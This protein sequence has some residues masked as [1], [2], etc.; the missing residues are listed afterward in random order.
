MVPSP[1]FMRFSRAH[2]PRLDAA[3][4]VSGRCPPFWLRRRRS[5]QRLLIDPR[6]IKTTYGSYRSSNVPTPRMMSSVPRGAATFGRDLK[7]RSHDPALREACTTAV[8]RAWYT[9]S[10]QV[11]WNWRAMASA[12]VAEAGGSWSRDSGFVRNGLLADQ[13]TPTRTLRVGAGPHS[14]ERSELPAL[15]SS[16]AST[17]AKGERG[18]ECAQCCSWTWDDLDHVGVLGVA[19]A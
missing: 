3:R 18:A 14:T 10:T 15:P 7:G 4:F 6:L 13:A 8:Y 2:T 11:R 16:P 1:Q 17:V 12:G 5:N 9:T 19:T